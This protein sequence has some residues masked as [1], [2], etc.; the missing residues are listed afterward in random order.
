MKRQPTEWEKIFANHMS[1]KRLISKIYKELIQL[2]SKKNPNEKLG[3]GSKQTVFQR[4][5]TDSQEAYKKV[6][7]IT[8][9]QGKCT[10]GRNVNWYSHYRKQYGIPQKIKTRTTI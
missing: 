1:Y 6:L 3:R 7:N 2:N 8:N 4:R 9:H 10:I 5:H